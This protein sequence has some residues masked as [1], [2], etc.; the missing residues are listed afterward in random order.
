MK[1]EGKKKNERNATK[2]KWERRKKEKK[3]TEIKE[4]KNERKNKIEF[5]LVR[6]MAYQ[7]L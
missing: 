2:R 3:N 1:S 6:F 4:R 7:T 5:D